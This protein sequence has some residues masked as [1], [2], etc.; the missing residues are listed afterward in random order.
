MTRVNERSAS[1]WSFSFLDPTGALATP[2]SVTYRID[3]LTSGA[4]ILALTGVASPASSID[5]PVSSDL[6]AIQNQGNAIER[7]RV[8]V[9]AVY[10]AGDEVHEQFDY[11][12]V[13]LNFVP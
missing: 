9:N 4:A 3:C 13:N 6:N 11:E 10:N 5:V 2:T 7:R 12:V 1:V 8:T